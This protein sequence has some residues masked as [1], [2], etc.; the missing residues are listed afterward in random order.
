[1][2]ILGL[3]WI[4]RTNMYSRANM[5]IRTNKANSAKMDNRANMDKRTNLYNR[6]NMDNRA[7]IDIRNN[8]TNMANIGNIGLSLL[9]YIIHHF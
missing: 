3:I 4:I 2:W 6:A 5:D 8:M 7:N 9:V 1:M